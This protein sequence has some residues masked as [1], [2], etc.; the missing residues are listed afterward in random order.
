MGGVLLTWE[1]VFYCYG[2]IFGISELSFIMEENGIIL[3][4]RER[5]RYRER[6][7]DRDG[8]RDRDR[9][10]NSIISTLLIS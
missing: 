2:D 1:C 3:S 4:Y 8:N 6:E 9:V 10:K 7:R 5:K